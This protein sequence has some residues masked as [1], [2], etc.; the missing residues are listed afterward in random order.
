MRRIV[1]QVF[2]DI[3]SSPIDLTDIW[4]VA[5]WVLLCLKSFMTSAA[6]LLTWVTYDLWPVESYCDWSLLF[7][8][9]TTSHVLPH[10]WIIWQILFDIYVKQLSYM[11]RVNISHQDILQLSALARCRWNGQM[12][13]CHLPD[14]S[15]FD[16]ISLDFAKL[17]ED[18]FTC[19]PNLTPTNVWLLSKFSNNACCIINCK[20]LGLQIWKVTILMHYVFESNCETMCAVFVQYVDSHT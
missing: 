3:S 9:V 12:T 19:R 2:Y 5:C 16:K 18:A 1:S 14:D 17:S 13:R 8:H 4:P 15:C 10:T 7:W 6:V 11:S 20:I